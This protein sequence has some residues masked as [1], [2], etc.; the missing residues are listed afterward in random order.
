MEKSSKFDL[1]ICLPY[2]LEKIIIKPQKM[3][4]WFGC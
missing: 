1:N 2:L 3:W 4:V